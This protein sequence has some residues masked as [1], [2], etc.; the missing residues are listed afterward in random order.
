[1]REGN[2]IVMKKKLAMKKKLL[3][4]D[5]YSV[6]TLKHTSVLPNGMTKQVAEKS[7]SCI[8]KEIHSAISFLF[9]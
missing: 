7:A 9:R 6:N 2:C 8:D 1:M 5:C 3:K 4:P